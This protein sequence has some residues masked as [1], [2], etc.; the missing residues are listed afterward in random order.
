[1]NALK[2]K[3]T[4]KELKIVAVSHVTHGF[5]CAQAMEKFLTQAGGDFVMITHPLYGTNDFKSTCRFFKKGSARKEK[6]GFNV[7]RPEALRYMKDALLTFLWGWGKE[8]K[9]DLFIGMNCLVSFVGIW[10]R[11]FGRVNKV[12]YYTADY[13]G[14]RFE[15]NGL[16][17]IYDWVDR[18]AV[19][20]ADMVWNVSQKISQRRW[21]QGVPESKTLVVPNTVDFDFIPSINNGKR[22]NN[23]V[24]VGGLNPGYGVEEFVD[25]LPWVLEFFPEVQIDIIG[26]GALELPIREKA[27]KLGGEKRVHFHGYMPYNKALEFLAQSSVGFAP[28]AAQLDPEHYLRYCDPSKVKAYM[29]CGCSVIIR[30]VPQLAQLIEEKEAGW[31]YDTKEELQDILK[32]VLSSPKSVT[33]KRERALTLAKQFENSSVFEQ[34]FA[35]TFERWENK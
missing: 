25:L 18:F 30:R 13:S 3:T 29:A 23:I 14:R 24:Y 6:I 26:G 9:Q 34:A 4:V 19:K 32:E 2:N 7:V 17:R 20:H 5:G 28:Y 12:I 21:D 35:K 16:N 1:M 11:R 8:G 33:Q 31:V 15:N 27:Q 10:L 22:R